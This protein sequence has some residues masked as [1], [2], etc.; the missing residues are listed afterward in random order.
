MG[1]LK[2]LVG[3]LQIFSHICNER[4][5]WTIEAGGLVWVPPCRRRQRRPGG[6]RAGGREGVVELADVGGAAV[7]IVPKNE[8]GLHNMP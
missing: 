7:L 6:A 2:K 1:M 4:S 3:F 8:P 5:P